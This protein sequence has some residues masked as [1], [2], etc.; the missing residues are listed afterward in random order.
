MSFIYPDIELENDV[1]IWCYKM[2]YKELYTEIR[3]KELKQGVLLNRAST[4]TQLYSPPPSSFQPPHSS[5]LYNILNVIRTKI[6][7]EIGQ[8]PQI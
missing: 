5:L 7:Y 4:F 2:V 1:L 3:N 8:F 6:S